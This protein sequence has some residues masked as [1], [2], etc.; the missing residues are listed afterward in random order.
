M[1]ANARGVVLCGGFALHMDAGEDVKPEEHIAAV[2]VSAEINDP[3]EDKFA[4]LEACFLEKFASGGFFGRFAL[5]EPA[6]RKRE[7][8]AR[9]CSAAFHQQKAL[10]MAQRHGSGEDNLACHAGRIRDRRETVNRNRC[11]SPGTF[12]R[13][14]GTSREEICADAL[15]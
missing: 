6:A 15:P 10:T 14:A 1:P 8:P 4:G 12:L 5:F 2:F 11:A 3:E 9:R 7:L 13:K